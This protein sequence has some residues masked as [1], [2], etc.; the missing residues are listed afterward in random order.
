MEKSSQKKQESDKGRNQQQK[1]G[2]EKASFGQG[3]EIAGIILK[4]VAT[5]AKKHKVGD[6]D[7]QK[8][9][10][11]PGV[12]YSLADELFTSKK[13][14]QLL[15]LV[16]SGVM[17]EACDGEDYFGK[18]KSNFNGYIGENLKNFNL[19]KKEKPRAET[20]LD[21]HDVSGRGRFNEIFSKINFDLEKLVMALDQIIRFCIKH[22]TKL[23]RNNFNFFLVK[24]DGG[25]SSNEEYLV[26][27]INLFTNGLSANAFHF[28][29]TIVW[30]I[31]ETPF[32]FQRVITPQI[33]ADIE[34]S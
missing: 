17:I 2:Q 19:N 1:G 21:I 28:G 25:S 33:I 9:V 32:L 34:K 11:K 26:I 14:A 6:E 27:S 7:V 4:A 10:G 29:S 13:P 23:L 8:I 15:N 3:L 22:P 30:G 12:A 5:A 24:G 18:P 20:L 31:S 16:E